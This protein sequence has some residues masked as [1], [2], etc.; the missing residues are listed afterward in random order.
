[1]PSPHIGWVSDDFPSKP[2]Q[3]SDSLAGS[4]GSSVVVENAYALAQHSSS[5]VLNRPPEFY[6]CLTIPVRVYCGPSSH[7]IDQQYPLSIPKHSCH[8]FTG[9]LCL[10]KFSQLRRRGMQPL[11][12]LLFHLR[13]EVVCS[14]FVARDNRIQ[15]V[16]LFVCIAV[17]KFTGRVHLL[18]LVIFCQHS[19]DP[20]CAHLPILQL[21]VKIQ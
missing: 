11:T 19:W 14:G 18:P 12:C 3:E 20:S 15:K 16:I 1:M 5:P 17:E 7:E 10:L 8:D 2:L 4:V 9:R 6:Q 13:C 21:A